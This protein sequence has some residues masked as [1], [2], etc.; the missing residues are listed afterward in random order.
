MRRGMA[1][2]G[3][4]K[5]RRST[6]AA[7]QTR[8]ARCAPAE[9]PLRGADPAMADASSAACPS[10]ENH[11]Y[12]CV[13]CQHEVKTARRLFWWLDMWRR[14]SGSS[15][16]SDDLAQALDAV[17]GEGNAEPQIRERRVTEMG[18]CLAD[19]S[20]RGERRKSLRVFGRLP[21]TGARECTRQASEKPRGRKPRESSHRQL[22]R[23][24]GIW[25]RYMR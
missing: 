9:C 6:R 16:V 14:V 1:R 20:P 13:Y 21:G 24:M 10:V 2:H 8:H 25:R 3:V 22:C 23:S 17:L 19:C 11:E 5:V 4:P 12:A 15:L 7:G 18:L